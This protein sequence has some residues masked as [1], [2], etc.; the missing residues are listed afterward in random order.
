MP[1]KIYG[2]VCTKGG[3]GKTT[4]G[5][6]TAAILAD[7][8]QRVLV[9][10]TDPVQALSLLFPL[11]YKADFAL[12]QLYRTA[13]PE[14]CISKTIYP[15]LDIVINDDP[16]GDSGHIVNFLR[17]SVTHFQHLHIAVQTLKDNYD[18]IFIDTQGARGLI[19]ESVVF[20]SDVLFSPITPNVL[21]AREF[22]NGTVALINKFKPKPGFTSIT[23]RPLPPVK[24]LINFWDK[25][26]IANQVSRYLRSEF[27]K[28]VDGQVTVLTSIIPR[29]T[30]YRE[31][32]ALGLPVHRL[33]QSRP[34]S[35]LPALQQMLE[36]IYE[37]EPKLIG[38]E[39]TWEGMTTKKAQGASH[40]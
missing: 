26:N 24:V 9:I 32:V 30:V 11:S 33:E 21:D 25:T 23:G 27:D 34:G 6:N 29:L 14:N 37:L 22:L 38:I 20:A 3:V 18:Y 16:G 1:A 2:I 12:T 15:N 5:A 31:A 35:S 17:E 10:D 13:N 19:Q 40:D 4:T 36:L 28:L 39:P 7:M 8:G